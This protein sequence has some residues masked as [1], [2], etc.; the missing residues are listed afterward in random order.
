MSLANIRRLLQED[1]VLRLPAIVAHA[2][3]RKQVVSI[4]A[5]Q[6]CPMEDASSQITQI[7]ML[8]VNTQGKVQWTHDIVAPH[9]PLPSVWLRQNQLDEAH[10][11]KSPTWRQGWSAAIHHMAKNNIMVVAHSEDLPVLQHQC[12]QSGT[13]APEF[14]HALALRSMF[15]ARH[16]SKSSAMKDMAAYYQVYLDPEK[17]LKA[18]VVTYAKLLDKMLA[19]QSIPLEKT[20]DP[21]TIGAL[22]VL[23]DMT[24]QAPPKT[25]DEAKKWVIRSEAG[26]STATDFFSKIAEQFPFRLV[27]NQHGKIQGYAVLVED[28][29]V[30]G[31]QLGLNLGWAQVYQDHHWRLDNAQMQAIEA[32]QYK[33]GS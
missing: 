23:H 16:P 24:T 33:G 5:L 8:H 29:W 27:Q 30:K 22:P 18:S 17:H 6:T 15:N 25:L 1:T 11:T 32:L 7:C 10:M 20:N 2:A 13:V 14:L 12:V 26:A 19:E 4:V 9:T 21:Q 31:T 28:D 3:S